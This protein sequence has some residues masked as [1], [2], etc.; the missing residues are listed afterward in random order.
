MAFK[1]LDRYREVDPL[2]PEFNEFVRKE[3]IVTLDSGWEIRAWIYW[4][5]RARA[6]GRH[7]LAGDYGGRRTE[8]GRF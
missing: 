3:T 1:V 8:H 6:S 2:K 5:R 7:I 4:L